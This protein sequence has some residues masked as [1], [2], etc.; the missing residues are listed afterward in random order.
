MPQGILVP[1]HLLVRDL[2]I[3]PIAN[4]LRAAS[5]SREEFINLAHQ[6]VTQ[7]VKWV[8]DPSNQGQDEFVQTPF[9][10]LERGV[11]DCE[12]SALA[13]LSILWFGG[14]PES[15]EV[16]GYAGLSHRWVEVMTSPGRWEVFDTTNGK[17]FPIEQRSAMGYEP[18]WEVTPFSFK[19]AGD[20]FPP[21]PLPF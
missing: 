11:G 19:P 12:D 2:R 20:L 17:Q 21:V 15:R 7:R 14:V 18:V 10:T 9:E 1:H 4:E 5:N 16:M 3:V 6:F 8:S 13:M